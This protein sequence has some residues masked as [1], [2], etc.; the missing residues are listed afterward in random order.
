MLADLQPINISIL[1]LSVYFHSLLCLY[2]HYVFNT[3]PIIC[4]YP[5]NGCNL[6]STTAPINQSSTRRII[7]DAASVCACACERE[8]GSGAHLAH[9]AKRKQAVFGGGILHR[10]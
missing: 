3:V 4:T 10:G 2:I 1:T 5:K 7:A 6:Q 8:R 9:D